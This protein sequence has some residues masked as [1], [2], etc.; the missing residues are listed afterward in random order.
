MDGYTFSLADYNDIPEIVDIY[1]NLIGTPGC[2]WDLD[3]PS[4]E[5]AKYDIDH[6]WLY[7]LKKDSKII[8]VASL[9]DFDELTH[10][11]W[12]PQKPCELARIGVTPSMQGK[13]VGSM[14]LQHIIRVAKDNGYDG[15]RFLVSKSNPAALALY[16]KNGF[17]RCGEVFMYEI[18]FY[19]YQMVFNATE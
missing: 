13:G 8:A 15:I 3:Y 16:D 12:L 2:A 17:E 5:T 14:I 9:G 6:Q 11:Q 19:C 18:Y 1:H 10:L 4:A 7:I